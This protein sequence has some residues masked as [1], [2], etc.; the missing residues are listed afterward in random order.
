MHTLNIVLM[1]IY[2]D[3]DWIKMILYLFAAER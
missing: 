2:V 1:W 3:N